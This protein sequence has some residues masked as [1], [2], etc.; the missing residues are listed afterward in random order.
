MER[1]LVS[2]CRAGP[3]NYVNWRA[4]TTTRRQS[5]RQPQIRECSKPTVVTAVGSLNVAAAIEVVI[6]LVHYISEMFSVA[7]TLQNLKGAQVWDFDLLDFNDFF[8]M[9]FL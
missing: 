8:I 6:K 3:T 9:K 5:Q 7:K 1:A 4:G 2:G